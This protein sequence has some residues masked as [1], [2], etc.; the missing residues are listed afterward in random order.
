[1]TSGKNRIEHVIQSL[2][3]FD[4]LPV[5]LRSSLDCSYQIGLVPVS[6]SMQDGTEI[7]LSTG[8]NVKNFP[9]E[10]AAAELPD[11]LIQPSGNGEE[12]QQVETSI[13]PQE[14]SRVFSGSQIGHPPGDPQD[15][16]VSEKSPIPPKHWQTKVGNEEKSDHFNVSFVGSRFNSSL[17]ENWKMNSGCATAAPMKIV[18]SHNHP[19]ENKGGFSSSEVKTELRGN[20]TNISAP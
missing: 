12:G 3:S 8:C 5:T 7:T 16:Y 13:Q 15:Y 2:K 1:M 14:I 20:G 9:T 10:T 17:S 4:N 6:S 19:T 18:S 11:K